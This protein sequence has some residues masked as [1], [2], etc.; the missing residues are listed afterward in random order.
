MQGAGGQP[1]GA[2]FA[3]DIP[4]EEAWAVLR[5]EPDATLIDVRTDAEWSY[6]GVPDLTGLGKHPLLVSWQR[7]PDMAINAEFIEMLHRAGLS[8]DA[9]NLFICRSG[10]RSRAAA[11]AMTAEGFSRCYNVAEGFEGDKD[12]SQHRGTTGGWKAA[13]LPWIQS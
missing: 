8:L 1:H 3:G 2:S 12:A 10:A 9:A 11:L 4:V 7:F 13:G 6:V 5:D